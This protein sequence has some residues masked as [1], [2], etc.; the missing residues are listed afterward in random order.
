MHHPFLIIVVV[1][2][3]VECIGAEDGDS[4]STPGGSIIS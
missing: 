3:V 4:D 1:V 2:V